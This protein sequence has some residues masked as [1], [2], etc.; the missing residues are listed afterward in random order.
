MRKQE[1]LKYIEGLRD[2]ALLKEYIENGDGEIRSAA[3]ASL[4]GLRDRENIPYLQELLRHPDPQ[5]VAGAIVGLHLLGVDLGHFE[6]PNERVQE[7]LFNL[8]QRGKHLEIGQTPD[9]IRN[10]L[11]LGD[12]SVMLDTLPESCIDLTF[13][14]PP[15]Y[16]AKLY[17]I[18]PSYRVYLSFLAGVFQQVKR[19]TKEGRFLI[20][21][22]SPV[23]LPRV[24]RENQ[25]KRYAIPYDLH[26]LM[27]GWDFIDDIIWVKDETTVKHRNAQFSRTR[28]PLS[29]KPNVVTEYILVYRKRTHKLLDWNIEQ[30]KHPEQS[31][32]EDYQSTNVWH[33][34][35]KTSRS[36]S[37]VLP[38]ELCEHVIKLYSYRG[39]IVL[40]PFAGLGTVGQAAKNLGRDYL[41]VEKDETYFNKMQQLLTK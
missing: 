23:I 25:S 8:S 15:Y 40:D 34:R 33:F 31:R 18:Y 32:V 13:T 20:V 39:D 21:N 12:C 7:I 1:V 19:V 3:L 10:T 2:V 38:I 17:S 28:R 22:I 26:P 16:N 6:H 37:A 36:H 24:H 11:L 14:S 4:I 5:I 30:Y 41:M 35:P 27:D 9:E 29:Y